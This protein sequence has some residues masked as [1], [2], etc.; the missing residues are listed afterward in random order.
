MP[1][2]KK[3]NDYMIYF[4]GI[5]FIILFLIVLQFD[6][7]ILEVIIGLRN[8]ILDK[9]MLMITSNNMQIALLLLASGIVYLKNKKKLLHLWLSV[10][11]SIMLSILLKIIIA[12]Q[13][14]LIEGI[15]TIS[16]LIKESYLTWDFSFPSNHT[17]FV[18]AML[19]FMPK[20]WFWFWL[21]IAIIIAFSR[22]YLGLHYLSD[23][24]AGAFLGLFVSHLIIKK[25]K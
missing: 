21:I 12:R 11:I 13:R 9:A 2:K 17:A 18:F 10:A 25:I 6:S 23:V 19:L 20:K 5:L 7:K 1:T 22:V 24:I 3:N 14:P 4:Y 15:S 16:N 8:N